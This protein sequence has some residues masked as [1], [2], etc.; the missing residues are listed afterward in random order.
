[1]SVHSD[2]RALVRLTGLLLVVLAG[3]SAR[4]AD[5]WSYGAS[6]H[7]EVYATGGAGTVREALTYFERTHT[8]F[9]QLFPNLAPKTKALTRL[10]IFS[11]DKQFAPYRPNASAAAFYLSGSDRDYIVMGRLDET[12]LPIVVHEY[13][14]LAL[15]HAGGVYPI[16]LNEGLAEF[17]SSMKLDDG[18]ITVGSIQPYALQYLQASGQAMFDLKRLFAVGHDSPEYNARAHVGMFY[19]QSTVLTHMLLT[20]DRYRPKSGQFMKAVVG[21]MSSAEALQTVYGKDTETVGRD[22]ANYITLTQFLSL[23]DPNKAKKVEKKSYQVRPA[24]AIEAGVVTA[25]LL[26]SSRDG[27]EAARTAFV[28][29]EQQ[30]PNDLSVLESRAFFELRRG[31]RDSALPYFARALE[32]GTRNVTLLKTYVALDRANAATIL[33]KAI[34]LAPNDAALRIEHAA[35]LLGERK[36]GQAFGALQGVTPTAEN[37]FDLYQ[38]MA[39]CYMV[40]NEPESAREAAARAT[41]YAASGRQQEYAAGL[42]KSIDDFLAQRK[43]AASRSNVAGAGQP[44]RTAESFSDPTELEPPARTSEAPPMRLL[45]GGSEV[46]II[47]VVGRLRNMVCTDGGDHFLEVFTGGQMLRL[48]FDDPLKVTVLG[49]KTGKADIHCGPQDGPI[50]VGYTPTADPARKTAGVVRVLDYRK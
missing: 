5:S 26:A 38:V 18:H 3:A 8:F 15:K 39:R 1:M 30:A 9:V 47:T 50:T 34:E 17:L 28:K 45:S 2:R 13:S 27:E 6:D 24:S 37:G 48:F 44:E 35:F 21:G 7:F 10:I 36:A 25:N 32:Q 49:T 46:Q 12:S 41:R 20:D 29:L 43:A 22:L 19:A 42:L 16:W 11:N 40:L 31:T 4:A 14:H 23:S 33:P